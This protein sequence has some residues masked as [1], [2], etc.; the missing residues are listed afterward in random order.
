M[1]SLNIFSRCILVLGLFFSIVVTASADDITLENVVAPTANQADES[2]AETASL[3]KAA[4]FLDS[5]A[6]T[7][8][9]GRIHG[10]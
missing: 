9:K 10:L 2:I 4:H 7:W 3:E 6:L 5:A 1:P 8:Q